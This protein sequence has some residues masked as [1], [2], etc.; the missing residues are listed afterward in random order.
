MTKK[1]RKIS[2]ASIAFII[3]L[4]ITAIIMIVLFIPAKSYN[5]KPGENVSLPFGHYFLTFAYDIDKNIN[6]VNSIYVLGADG[7]MDGITQEPFFLSE[8]ENTCTVEFWVNSL[9]KKVNISIRQFGETEDSPSAHVETYRI[10]ST[11]YTCTLML[12]L[13]IAICI[14]T[15]LCMKIREKAIVISKN[16]LAKIGIFLIVFIISCLPLFHKNL[17]VGWDLEIHLVR[18][19][20]IMQGYMAGQFPVRVEPVYNGGYGYAFSTYYGGLFFNFAVI[21][22]MLGFSLQGAYKLY[23]TIINIATILI[24]YYS[25]KVIFD[26]EKTAMFGSIFYSLSLYRLFD[27]YQRGAVGEYTAI[28]FIPLV[29][30]GLWKIYTESTEDEGYKKLWIL[31]VLGFSG[32]IQSHILSTEI[33]GLFTV[34]I[35][36]VLFKKTFRKRTFMVLL[37]IVLYTIV[38]NIW[39]LYPFFE[40]YF[41]EDTIISENVFIAEALI[42]DVSLLDMFGYNFGKA[43]NW[44]Y[45]VKAGVGPSLG[46]IA[47]LIV[48]S[49][50]NRKNEKQYKRRLFFVAFFAALSTIICTNRFPWNPII[51]RLNSLIIRDNSFSGA[52]ETVRNCILNTQYA[53]RF[54]VISCIMLT[55][56]ACI[57]YNKKDKIVKYAG[58]AIVCIIIMQALCSNVSFI[59]NGFYKQYL[60]VR[61]DD[62]DFSC[63]T[64]NMEYIPLT[65][66]GEIPYINQFEEMHACYTTNAKASDYSKKYTNITVHVKGADESVG[67]VEFPLLYYRGYKIVDVN[68]REEFKK[69]KIGGI[70]RLGMIVEPGYEGDIKVYYAGET[71]WHIM[72][73]VSIIAF[74]SMLVNIIHQK[75]LKKNYKTQK[76]N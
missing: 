66:D 5:I 53:F 35:C 75:K 36:L 4:T 74:I 56:T 73:I 34:I 23:A 64:G 42:N 57:M 11:K 48:Y 30:A 59:R 67:I 8:A 58:Y 22:R 7:T 55:L 69:F 3:E 63:S 49:L 17:L 21:A 14:L 70:A 40:N 47:V 76:I 15:F 45:I 32:I 44:Y 1:D 62:I 10:N 33:C 37:K 27:L 24:S 25:F 51:A 28:T 54:M 72:D 50:I 19:E 31:P 52:A 65:A 43:E 26:D 71:M 6:N 61:E 12:L 60:N 18:I 46:I 2:S 9:W 29:A 41:F 39:F 20:G 13:M 38:L 68:T 16:E